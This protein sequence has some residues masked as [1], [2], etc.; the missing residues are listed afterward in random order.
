LKGKI[1]DGYDFGDDAQQDHVAGYLLGR[2]ALQ[3]AFAQDRWR[4]VCQL[5][6]PLQPQGRDVVELGLIVD[7][8][9]SSGQ[10]KPL[11]I[12]G[13]WRVAA[14]RKRNPRI[15]QDIGIFLSAVRHE[16]VQ[17]E[18]VIDIAHHGCLR[19]AVGT[20]GGDRHDAMLVEQAK[21]ETLEL[22]HHALP[23]GRTFQTYAYFCVSRGSA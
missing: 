2:E 10:R 12:Q 1:Q 9:C 11:D 16:A 22:W 13:P 3:R 21:Y 14:D 5:G 20:V 19:P 6:V 8:G 15:A 18:T 17:Q 7:R 4:Q 23:T